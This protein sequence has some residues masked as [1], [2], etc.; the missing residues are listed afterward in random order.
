MVDRVLVENE[1]NFEPSNSANSSLSTSHSASLQLVKSVVNGYKFR[2]V[3]DIFP[4]V[5]HD[6]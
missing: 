1:F 3:N 4:T 6:A 2:L 5:N